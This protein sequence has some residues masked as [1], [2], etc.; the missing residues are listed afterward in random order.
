MLVFMRNPVKAVPPISTYIWLTSSSSAVSTETIEVDS[1][2][3][4]RTRLCLYL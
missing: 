2:C 3:I 1:V 4:C